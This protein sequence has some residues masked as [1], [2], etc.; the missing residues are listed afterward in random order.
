MF[1]VLRG[2]KKLVLLRLFSHVK[3][4]TNGLLGAI[5]IRENGEK[6]HLHNSKLDIFVE[7]EIENQYIGCQ[8]K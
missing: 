4:T 1:I 2:I 7:S 8:G 3:S 5:T 6:Y